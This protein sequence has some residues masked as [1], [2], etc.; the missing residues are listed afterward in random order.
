MGIEDIDT[1]KIQVH[2]LLNRLV[3]NEVKAELLVFFHNNPGVID[4]I[5]GIARRIGRNA[6]SVESEIA[7]F[8]ALGLIQEHVIDRTKIFKFN[9]EKDRE[10]QGAIQSY[11]NVYGQL[12]KK[13]LLE[14]YKR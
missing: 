7:D 11:L 10:I 5:E 9:R 13:R 6:K 8:I 4:T 3:G 14:G 1:L 12:S 2:N